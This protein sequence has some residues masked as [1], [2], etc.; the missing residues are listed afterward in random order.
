M[1]SWQSSD[2]ILLAC[3]IITTAT[4]LGI[5]RTTG[6]ITFFTIQESGAEDYRFVPLNKVKATAS[7]SLAYMI[8]MVVGMTALKVLACSYRFHT[9]HDCRMDYAPVRFMR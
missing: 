9:L 2:N 6:I 1:T 7:M 3:Q 8:Y 4:I 5:L